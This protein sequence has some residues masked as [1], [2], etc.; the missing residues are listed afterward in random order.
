MPHRLDSIDS[1]SDHARRDL[2]K[3][4]RSTDP[5]TDFDLVQPR[6][7]S[8]FTKTVD[9]LGGDPSSLLRVVGLEED[10]L[11]RGDEAI[12][13]SQ[14]VD[15]VALA[16]RAMR[17]PDFGMR[18][19]KVQV[20]TIETPLRRL[21]RNSRTLIEGL[22]EV[23]ENCHVHSAAAAIWLK[24]NPCE[25]TVSVGHDIL[26]DGLA[27]RRQTV[28][29][30]LLVEYL[31]CLEAT[32]GF[33]RARRI[34]FRHEP[35]SP[36]GVYRANF[37]CD[38]RF[39]QAADAIVYGETALECQIT[40]PDLAVRRNAIAHIAAFSDRKRPLHA[41]VRFLVLHALGAGDCTS[42]QVAE[43]LG[44]HSRTLH[45]RLRERGTSFQHIK[46]GVRRD[47]LAMYLDQ[48]DFP[49]SAVSERLGFAEQSAM[50]RFCRQWLSSA[51]NE[52]R[53]ASRRMERPALSEMGKP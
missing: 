3:A 12:K 13:Y 31:T 15:L 23:I 19:G 16:A 42:E 6:I 5:A 27:D 46:S 4:A 26:I 21:L 17:C 11:I 24:R 2:R 39:G 37:G 50:N 9:A 7:L 52:R 25:D 38:V 47:M 35:I 1:W 18:L 30:I 32:A 28:E 48:T 33:A 44:V 51:P 40:A 8:G 49:L 45:R 43:A 22:R 41:T 29:Q 10:R 36:P 14:A 20:E 34:E 53:A